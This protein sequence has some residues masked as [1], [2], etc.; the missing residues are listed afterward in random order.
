MSVAWI[1]HRLTMLGEVGLVDAAGR[2]V[3][4]LLRQPK[5]I[6]FLAY[7]ALP[8]PGTWHRRDSI[9]GT[10]WPEHDQSRARSALRSALHTVRRHLPEG[11]IK[12]RG[13]YE[14]SVDGE[15][16]TTDVAVMK[17]YFAAGQYADALE[18]YRGELL[19]GVYIAQAEGFDQWLEL[20]RSRTRSIAQKSAAHL[21][22]ICEKQGNLP[23]AVDAARRAAELD[24]DDE[25][26]TRRWIA[27]L[28]RVGDRAQ[29]FAVYERFRD[30]MSEAFG[31][32]PSAETIALLDDVRTRRE[33]SA[34]TISVSGI[35]NAAAPHFRAPHGSTAVPQD[36]GTPVATRGAWLR[37][38]APW[39]AAPIVIAM[40]GWAAFSSQPDR[41]DA[42]PPRSLVILPMTN[43]THDPKLDYVASGIAE[44]IARRLEGIGGISV[45]SGARSDWHRST[46]HDIIDLG[47]R[48][49]F[50]IVLKSSVRKIGD[51]LEVTAS[52]I[53]ASTGEERTIA[54]QRFLTSGIRDAESRLAAAIGG[55]VFRAPIPAPTLQR[56]DEID[57]ESY[58]L[59]LEGVHE[60]L[61]NVQPP[62]GT[63]GARYTN[64][65]AL[66]TQA[67]NIDP[68]NARAWSGLSSVASA[69]VT[70]D[71][72]PF[73]EGYDR[74]TAAAARALALDSLQGSAWATLAIMRAFK[75]R[76]LDVGLALIKRAQA[77]EPGNPEVFLVKGTLLMSA[78]LYDQAIDAF[79]MAR[80][81]DPLTSNY[82]DKEASAEL[83][84]GRPG[85]ALALY[86]AELAINPSDRLAR[87]GLT[88]SFAQLGRWNEA[89][90]SWRNDASLAGDSSLTAA[91]Q[92][93]RGENAYWALKHAAARKR[94]DAMKQRKDRMRPLRVIH[95]SFGVGDTASGYAALEKLTP[96]TTPALY[97]LECMPETD[98]FRDTPHFRAVLGRIGSLGGG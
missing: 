80:Q 57:P 3:D 29:A 24:P 39:L 97:R 56:R 87:A 85:K 5:H 17:R 38:R 69:Q 25:G 10:F 20:Q 37:Y 51:S 44:G 88:R 73:D 27:L 4:S 14:L 81:L 32:R 68:L 94:L 31:I 55:V 16:V 28:D 86:Q 98:E 90:A 7:L 47:Q 33:P 93:A 19:P 30:H 26:A 48:F 21:A 82:L 59:M 95:T 43:E 23:G 15:L 58:R 84:A 75:Y 70:T 36:D 61:S 6:A 40:V 2:D 35:T 41:R 83:C 22:S 89:I 52:A 67:V 45:R 9:I 63:G 42:A 65:V 13:D 62:N 91:L 11:A 72:V 71:F 77:A 74:A 53:E 76:D 8:E 50:T 46:R 12:S 34:A 49:G 96:A 64:A 66:F 78:H 60:L 92:N 54:A 18:Q 79:R 1:M